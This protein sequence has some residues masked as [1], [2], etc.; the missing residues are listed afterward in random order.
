MIVT[1][2][3]RAA[4]EVNYLRGDDSS[5]WQRGLSQYRQVVYSNLW[6]GIDLKLREELRNAQI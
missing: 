4:G 2:E 3:E 5:R 1:G 6:P